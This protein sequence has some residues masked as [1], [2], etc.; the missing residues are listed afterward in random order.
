LL[1]PA[2]G[3]GDLSLSKKQTATF[4]LARQ[5]LLSATAASSHMATSQEQDGADFHETNAAIFGQGRS[6]LRCLLLFIL[7]HN[8]CASLHQKFSKASHQSVFFC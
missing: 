2:N 5:K 3:T 1:A 4:I 6:L 8:F 7:W